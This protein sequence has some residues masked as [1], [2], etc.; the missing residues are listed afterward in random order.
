MFA[1]DAATAQFAQTA[2]CLT[3]NTRK[4]PVDLGEIMKKDP[5]SSCPSNDARGALFSAQDSN[6]CAPRIT[7]PFGLPSF[8]SIEVKLSDKGNMATAS[9]KDELYLYPENGG[10]G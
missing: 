8:S 9:F 7:V 4:V 3:R 10:E 2:Q 5:R 1:Q 6:T